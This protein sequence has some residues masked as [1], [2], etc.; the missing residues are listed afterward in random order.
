MYCIYRG[1]GKIAMVGTGRHIMQITQTSSRGWTK[2][3]FANSVKWPQMLLVIAS[4][5]QA[6]KP[7]LNICLPPKKKQLVSFPMAW[8]FLVM[9]VPWN[10]SLCG[11][12]DPVPLEGAPFHLS[13]LWQH[14]HFRCFAV[15]L[16]L[17]QSSYSS[18]LRRCSPVNVLYKCY[19]TGQSLCMIFHFKSITLLKAI[20]R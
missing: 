4:H 15:L 17:I 3:K 6:E 9:G 16:C 8:E 1:H 10:I 14:L 12:H 19:C 7:T 2:V 18:E 13:T 5:N 11:L 20:F